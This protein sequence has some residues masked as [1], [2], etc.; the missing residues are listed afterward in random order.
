LYSC[1]S[2]ERPYTEYRC[3]PFN[4]LAFLYDLRIQNP[5]PTVSLRVHASYTKPVH[6]LCISLLF[7]VNGRLRSCMFDLG[8][9]I[10]LNISIVISSFEY[11]SLKS[12]I[13][14]LLNIFNTQ[15]FLVDTR[16]RANHSDQQS[17]ENVYIFI[18]SKF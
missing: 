12:T 10:N 15:H 14:T 16:Y 8:S 18:Y 7:S 3:L 6:D 2:R 1:D 9:T 5:F 4:H 11:I 17:F 13:K